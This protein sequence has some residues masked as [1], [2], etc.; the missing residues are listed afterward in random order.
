MQMKRIAHQA[1]ASAKDAEDIA[2]LEGHMGDLEREIAEQ[3]P[4][5]PVEWDAARQGPRP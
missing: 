5:D 2:W 3:R 1:R 4:R